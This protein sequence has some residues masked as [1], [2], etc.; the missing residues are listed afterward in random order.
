MTEPVKLC[1]NIET[2]ASVKTVLNGAIQR[3]LTD[4]LVAGYH[5]N[6]ELFIA[7]S[8]SMSRAEAN[9]LIDVV[10]AHIVAPSTLDG[11]TDHMEE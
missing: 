9:W 1:T 10:K 5:P 2:G 11:I 4:V 3:D 7:V 6:G 8:N